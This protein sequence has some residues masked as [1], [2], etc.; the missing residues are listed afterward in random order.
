MKN[1]SRSK[2]SYYVENFNSN[3]TACDHGEHIQLEDIILFYPS[4][5]L[6][7]DVEYLK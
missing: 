6:Y 5:T 3:L 2:D 7:L 4:G 1:C